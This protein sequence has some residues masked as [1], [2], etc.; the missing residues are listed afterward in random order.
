MYRYQEWSISSLLR[1]LSRWLIVANMQTRY[2]ISKC[3]PSFLIPGWCWCRL[4]N[5]TVLLSSGCLCQFCAEVQKNWYHSAYYSWSNAN[6]GNRVFHELCR[7]SAVQEVTSCFGAWRF[8]TILTQS[9]PVGFEVFTAMW[10]LMVVFW[11][12]VPCKTR[13]WSCWCLTLISQFTWGRELTTVSTSSATLKSQAP[14]TNQIQ[15][16]AYVI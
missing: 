3:K 6:T 15:V 8:G 7:C 5:H 11:V 1:H 2:S 16:S 9:D 4:H 13:T 14:F 12:A 10:I